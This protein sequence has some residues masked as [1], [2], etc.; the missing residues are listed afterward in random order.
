MTVGE[1]PDRL[2]LVQWP[3]DIDMVLYLIAVEDTEAASLFT[4]AGS[5]EGVFRIEE[6]W[7][8]ADPNPNMRSTV[9][10]LL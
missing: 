8:C 6:V 5:G 3:E 2:Q 10:R 7:G 1:L 4:D 9:W